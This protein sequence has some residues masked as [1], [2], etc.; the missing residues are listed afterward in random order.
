MSAMRNVTALSALAAISLVAAT[1]T[2]G[3]APAYPPPPDTRIEEVVD[4]MHGVEIPDPFRWLED[5]DG[6]GTRAWLDE[7]NA[8][9]ELVVGQ[10]P[11]RTWLENRLTELMDRDDI[12][13]PRKAG[14]YEYFTMRR[15]G[16]DLPI[17][18]R[19]PAPE[20]EGEERTEGE[21]QGKGEGEEGED[22]PEPID[23]EAEYEVVIDPHLMDPGHTTRVSIVD[24]S[25]DGKLMIYN[26]RDGGQDEVQIRIRDLESGED[27]SDALPNALYG[28]VSFNDDATGFTYTARSREIGPRIKYHEMGAD[29][30]DDEV[31]FGEGYGPETFVGMSEAG[32]GRYRIF[33]VSHGWA[34]TEMHFQ[35]LERGGPIQPLVDDAHAHFYPRFHD[36]LL[37]VRTDLDASNGRLLTIDLETPE[38]ESWREII[39]EG[40]DMMEGFTFIDDKI[41][42]SYLHDVSS[43]IRIFEM[44]GT[45][46][47][48]VEV[49]PFHTASIRE[50]GEGKVALT[51]RSFLQPEITYEID[52]ETGA[53]TVDDEEEIDFDP[54]GIVVE[55]VW[56]TSKDGTRVPMYVV[57]HED[58]EM[59]GQNPTWLSGY[60][61]F[62]A[63]RRPGFS[64]TAVVWLELG[65][66]YAVANMRGGG[67]YGED[68][69][70]GGML[71]NKQH[72]FD[73]FIAAAEWL[74]EAGYTSPDKLAIQG[75]S[76]GGLLVG[77]ALTQRPDLFRAVLCGF[78]DVDILRFPHYTRNN[79]APALL[80]YGNAEVKEEFEFIR[81]WSPYQNVVDGTPY[82][83][84]MFSTGDLDTRVPPLGAR[85]M[86]AR[87]QRATTSG[88][89]VI[90]RYH[91]KAGHAGSRGVPMSRRIEDTAMEMAFVA[92][93]LGAE[94]PSR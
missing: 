53:R 1:T 9:A 61:G 86:T 8:Y 92:Q 93:Q 90:L 14:E 41:Y 79:N 82:P 38:R 80:E 66:V 76:N 28:N 24:F 59:N 91:P 32:E 42:V 6:S 54:T 87:L 19:R 15:K 21:G 69:H 64:T 36:G 22:E 46:A 73:D 40:E 11:T 83:A 29:F 55:Q 60:G 16:E 2:I 17:I 65:G 57:H 72:V 51:L 4:V 3:C 27:L 23:P 43:Q 78:P 81:T 18:Y 94:A 63:S 48:E 13:S 20:E 25:K 10:T 39:P 47:G 30:A 35:D 75:T 45:A 34:R 44:D 50:A 88:Y 77:A 56:A 7:Q 70:R 5:R 58:V 84:V 62:Y 12:G 67:E 85:K 71:S 37:Y 49:P 33:T 74:I 68:W 26:I 89:P 31:V 52:L